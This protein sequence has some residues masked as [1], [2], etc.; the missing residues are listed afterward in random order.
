MA[1]ML[2]AKELVLLK[3]VLTCE[4]NVCKKVRLYGRILTNKKLSEQL[5]RLADSHERRFN[6][7]YELLKGE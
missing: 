5:N 1:N 4:E 6:R 7:L 2:T 3:D